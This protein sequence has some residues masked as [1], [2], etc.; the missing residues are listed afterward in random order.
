MSQLIVQYTAIAV[1]HLLLM[2]VLQYH[3]HCHCHIN[4]TH[5]KCHCI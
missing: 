2:L 3:A 5:N 4:V 1:N